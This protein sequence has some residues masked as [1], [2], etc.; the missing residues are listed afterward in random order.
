MGYVMVGV[1]WAWLPAAQTEASPIKS[2][3]L[4]VLKPDGDA[5]T[6]PAREMLYRYLVDQAR[7]RF[8]ARRKVIAAIKTPEDIARRQKA[9]R[10]WFLQSLGDLPERTP[11]NPR[12][13]GTLRRDDYLI[14]NNLA[15]NHPT[16]M[17]RFPN[18]SSRE[19]RLK[20]IGKE[21]RGWR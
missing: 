10:A 3:D 9:L 1:M 6:P 15:H 8:D 16:K 21:M 5:R 13:M 4:Q 7:G 11:L 18:L 14:K 17:G 2:L 12:V 20:L 19:S